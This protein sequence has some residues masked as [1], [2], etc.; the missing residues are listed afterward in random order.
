[1]ENLQTAI[2]PLLA[3]PKLFQ[4]L[5][6]EDIAIYGKPAL[7]FLIP[8][9]TDDDDC[10]QKRQNWIDWRAAPYLAERHSEY[11]FNPQSDMSGEGPRILLS[12]V[13]TTPTNMDEYL[14]TIHK[15]KRYTIRG[16]KAENRGYSVKCFAP[17][18][19][20]SDIYD[21]IHS[22]TERQGRQIAAMFADRARDW[23]FPEYSGFKHPEYQD[24]CLGVFDPEGRLV[25]YLLG[26]RV[27]HHIQYDEI[28][29]HAE[30]IGSDVMHLLHFSFLKFCSEQ[31]VVPTCLNYGPWYSGENPY[32]PL[33]GLNAWKR[34]V[35][36][37]PA[38]LILASS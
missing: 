19:F 20:S 17:A 36:F 1:M 31:E 23:H 15:D 29:G 24:I 32:S 22:S 28:M 4:Q 25:A 33:G 10:N 18:E 35:G 7:S 16:R 12:A 11:M 8:P 34:R 27:G 26:K 5:T 2:Q 9:I 37:Q 3:N 38:Y 13:M 6:E 30:H 14:A 21:I